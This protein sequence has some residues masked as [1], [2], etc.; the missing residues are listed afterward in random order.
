MITKAQ[1]DAALS[2]FAKEI[3]REIDLKINAKALHLG[4]KAEQDFESSENKKKMIEGEVFEE[5]ERALAERKK[6]C[7][8]NRTDIKELEERFMRLEETIS[9]LG[10][11]DEGIGDDVNPL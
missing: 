1:L 3:E 4:E 8:K 6:D 9:R 7:E 11:Q 5:I 10:L 2:N